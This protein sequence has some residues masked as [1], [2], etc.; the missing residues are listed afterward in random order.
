[1][2]LPL[3]KELFHPFN[4]VLRHIFKTGMLKPMLGGIFSEWKFVQVVSGDV[5]IQVQ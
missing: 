3:V 2:W 1:M 4:R 5:S